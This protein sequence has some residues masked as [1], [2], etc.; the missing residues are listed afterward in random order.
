MSRILQNGFDFPAWKIR[1]L[2]ASVNP[3]AA[4][5]TIAHNLLICRE[6]NLRVIQA[7][8]PLQKLPLSC[9]YFSVLSCSVAQLISPR[10][11]EGKGDFY[12]SSPPGNQPVRLPVEKNSTTRDILQA[13]QYGLHSPYFPNS[14]SA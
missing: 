12:T 11:T 6:R 5:P 1:A 13:T 8:A 3:D 7:H 4:D 10:N 14:A 9:K 2:A